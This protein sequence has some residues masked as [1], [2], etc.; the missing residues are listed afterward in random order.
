MWLDFKPFLVPI[1]ARKSVFKLLNFV[2]ALLNWR[3]QYRKV[4]NLR[5]MV[6]NTTEWSCIPSTSMEKDSVAGISS[7]PP[8]QPSHPP[9]NSCPFLQS[10]R[11]ILLIFKLYVN[12]ISAFIFLGVRLLSVFWAA[13]TL[14]PAAIV[15]DSHCITLFLVQKHC[16][17]SSVLLTGVS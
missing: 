15:T 14:L 7:V 8:H 4:D 10:H 9:S 2:L 13:S 16:D 1:F 12:G 3:I 6:W 5:C 17:F 11:W